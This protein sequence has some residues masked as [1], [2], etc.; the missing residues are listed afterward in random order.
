M[1]VKASCAIVTP[2]S[3]PSDGRRP[4]SSDSWIMGSPC[5]IAMS[6][7]AQIETLPPVSL[8][9][10]HAASLRP[11]QWTSAWSSQR[12]PPGFVVNP[13]R[14]LI[15]A[16]AVDVFIAG[17]QQAGAAGLDHL[18]TKVLADDMDDN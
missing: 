4:W 3:E 9:S 18:R 13:P 16:D 11:M 6:I 2:W 15:E 10:R 5:P 14:R 12:R 17:A 7:G 1:T 8:I